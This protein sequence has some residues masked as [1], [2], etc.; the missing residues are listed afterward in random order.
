MQL[1]NAAKTEEIELIGVGKGRV[2]EWS[3]VAAKKGLVH[4][5]FVD[6]HPNASHP[7]NINFNHKLIIN[8]MEEVRKR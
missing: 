6:P 3:V 7:E 2:D 1:F 5:G 4:F 8:F